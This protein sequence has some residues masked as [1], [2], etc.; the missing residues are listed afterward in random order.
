MIFGGIRDFNLFTS[1]A[2]ELVGTVIEQEILYYKYSLEE[3][4]VNRYVKGL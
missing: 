1:I 3:T 4:Q 2:R